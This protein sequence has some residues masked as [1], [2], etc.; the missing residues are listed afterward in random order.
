MFEDKKF[1]RER[2]IFL[3]VSFAAYIVLKL[4]G[5]VGGN[6]RLPEL[7]DVSLLSQ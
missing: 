3:V 2:W 7:A 1:I 6:S 5:E 4:R